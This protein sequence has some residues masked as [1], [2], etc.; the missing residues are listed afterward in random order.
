MASTAREFR[1]RIRIVKGAQEVDAKSCIELL[2]L[3]AVQ[4]TELLIRAEGDD[5]RE[6]VDALANLIESGFSE[7]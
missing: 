3:A 5:A 1:A 4:G 7:T 6:A 2:T